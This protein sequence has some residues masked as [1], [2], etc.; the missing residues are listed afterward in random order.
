MALTG[1]L[2]ERSLDIVRFDSSLSGLRWFADPSDLHLE[3]PQ[4]HAQNGASL[5]D[6]RQGSR[7]RLFRT[8]GHWPAFQDTVPTEACRA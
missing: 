4:K 2:T 1:G 6:D 7:S 3:A 5:V 8:H